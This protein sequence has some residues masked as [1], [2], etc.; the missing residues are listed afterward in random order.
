MNTKMGLMTEDNEDMNRN[1][2]KDLLMLCEVHLAPVFRSL[3][4]PLI[5]GAFKKA[6]LKKFILF[7]FFNWN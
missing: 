5:Y 1:M 6:F 2:D 7:H 3:I 4:P